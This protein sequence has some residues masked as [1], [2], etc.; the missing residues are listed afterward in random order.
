MLGGR[1]RARALAER[2][3]RQR[4]RGAARAAAVVDRAIVAVARRVLA[5]VLRREL[6]RT[7]TPAAVTHHDIYT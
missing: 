3:V 4:R 6:G 7:V 1:P 2:A 5:P